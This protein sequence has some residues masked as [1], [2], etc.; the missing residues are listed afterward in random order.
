M[1]ELILAKKEVLLDIDLASYCEGCPNIKPPTA[2][3]NYIKHTSPKTYYGMY[4]NN[5]MMTL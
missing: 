5:C 4:C 3:L 2:I 1:L